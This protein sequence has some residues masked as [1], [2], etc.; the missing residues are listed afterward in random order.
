MKSAG[1]D[2]SGTQV[3]LARRDLSA[4]LDDLELVP[5]DDPRAAA[6]PS[7]ELA[8]RADVLGLHDLVHRARLVHA[9]VIGRQGDTAGAGTIARQVNEWAREHEH[10]H[11]LARS[12]RLLSAFY[13]RIG[14]MSSALEHAVRAV[15]LLGPD[16]R[17]RLVADHVMGLALAY[18]RT[19]SFDAARDRFAVVLGIADR[20]DDTDLRIAA[21]NNLAY[22]EYW[23]GEP[24][25]SM[26]VAAEMQRTAEH[27]DLPLEAS[28]LD[29]VSR[30]QMMMGQ[31]EAAERTLDPVFSPGGEALLNEA[32]DLAELLLTVAECQRMIGAHDRAQV[33]LERSAQL[34]EE[35]DLEEVRVRVMEEQAAVFAAVGDFRAAYEQHREFHAAS[36][37][38]FSS[39]R[40][41][42]ARILAAVFETEE[43]VRSSKRFREMSLRDPL[44]GL[45]NRRYVD[46]R[47]P[48]L[49]GRSR[50]D[51]TSL[52]VAILDLDYFKAVNDQLSHDTG[53]EVLRRLA[54]LLQASAA[55]EGFAARLGGEEFVLVLP[56]VD[57]ETAVERCEA[58]RRQVREQPW[59]ELVGELP[60]TVSIGVASAF[61]GAQTFNELLSD[62]DRRLYA[63]KRA[64]RDRVVG[65]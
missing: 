42:R 20:T 25:R 18:G 64:G 38:I 31:Y 55:D 49:I 27:H 59:A 3:D 58:L 62:A 56:G 28:F 37:A 13:Q 61:A 39:E 60:V 46:D 30:A 21:L 19:K 4:A 17:P 11:L 8:A 43:A 7:L 24:E 54:P 51:A 9:D 35:R 48:A 2:G 16:A 33:S 6:G 52:A 29:T 41:A 57:S 5:Y 12:E 36:E 44:T 53:D 32:D 26:E 40:D 1:D 65:P 47:V 63:A 15:E 45:Y 10:R 23:A 50:V 14:D 22:V 34:C